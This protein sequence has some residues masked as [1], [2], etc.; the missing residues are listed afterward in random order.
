MNKNVET[1]K[2]SYLASTKADI[3]KCYKPF[4]NSLVEELTR[5]FTV[6]LD[7]NQE[8]TELS[9]CLRLSEN[10]EDP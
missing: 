2:G 8:F 3:V 4:H 7:D 9:F 10:A 6:L 5:Y 1:S